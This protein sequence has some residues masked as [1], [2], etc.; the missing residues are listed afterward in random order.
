MESKI[1]RYR[2]LQNMTL[3]DLAQKTGLSVSYVSQIERGQAEPGISVLR[4]IASALGVGI[5]M[6]IEDEEKTFDGIALR[7]DSRPILRNKD[8][9]II[10]EFLTPL[11]SDAFP[12]KTGMVKFTLMPH[13]QSSETEITHD[14]EECTTII[15]GTMTLRANGQPTILNVGDSCV[16]RENQ[17]HVFCNET[18]SP[19]VG[20][21][22]FTPLVWGSNIGLFGK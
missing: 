5:V 7:A 9:S 13:K 6:I 4:K 12:V 14:S 17:S 11:S 22:C 1:K 19:V 18:D 20:I 10:Y 16:I 21:S 2:K 3:A 15:S 8:G